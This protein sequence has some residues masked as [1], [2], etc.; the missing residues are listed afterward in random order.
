MLA[1]P[2]KNRKYQRTY[3]ISGFLYELISKN[4]TYYSL[5]RLATSSAI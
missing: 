5:S 2:I 4:V 3:G 1:Y